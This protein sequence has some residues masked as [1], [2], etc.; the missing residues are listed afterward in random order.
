MPPMGAITICENSLSYVQHAR[1]RGRL[2]MYLGLRDD[3][4]NSE[5]GNEFLDPFESLHYISTFD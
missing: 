4:A 5:T 3:E 2:H 1:H